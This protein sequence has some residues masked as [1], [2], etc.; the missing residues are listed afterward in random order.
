MGSYCV[1]R[2][3]RAGMRERWIIIPSAW[4]HQ[5]FGHTTAGQLAITMGRRPEGGHRF[6][7]GQAPWRGT[8]AQCLT[9]SFAI[10]PPVD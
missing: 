2:Q 9:A 8:Q 3:A 10:L 5:L 4:S 1:F 6:L 7:G